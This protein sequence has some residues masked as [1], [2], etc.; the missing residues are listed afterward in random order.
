MCGS[1][2]RRQLKKVPG[3]TDAVVDFPTKTATVTVV[4]GTPTQ[5]IIDGLEDR[6]TATVKN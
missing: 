6:F 4:E 3:V 2:V 1:A 5:A